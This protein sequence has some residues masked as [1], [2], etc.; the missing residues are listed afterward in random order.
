MDGLG[1]KIKGISYTE[2]RIYFTHPAVWTKE[3]RP[4]GKFFGNFPENLSQPHKPG[5]FH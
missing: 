4:T 5:F 3:R 1:K 2:N